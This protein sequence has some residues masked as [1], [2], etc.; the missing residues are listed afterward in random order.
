MTLLDVPHHRLDQY[1]QQNHIV[2]VALAQLSSG[3]TVA[4]EIR[5]DEEGTIISHYDLPDDPA[6]LLRMVV[7]RTNLPVKPV[8]LPSAHEKACSLSASREMSE[9]ALAAAETRQERASE[10]QDASRAWKSIKV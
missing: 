2:A 9:R 3:K 4:A 7:E 6:L 1:I 8:V 10:R 5:I